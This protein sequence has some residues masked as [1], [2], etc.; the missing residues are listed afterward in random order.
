VSVY[1]QAFQGQD[2]VARYFR[3]L[4]NRID[5]LRDKQE[6]ELLS[7]WLSGNLYDC[8][9]GVGR[10]VGRLPK[11]TSYAGMDISAEFIAFVRERYPDVR[12]SVGDLKEGIREANDS[13]DSVL[14]LRSLSAIGSLA[15]ILPEMVRI[16]RPG[17][18]LVID[19]GRRSL[20][21]F[22]MKGQVLPV[23]AEDLES[24]LGTLNVDVQSRIRVDGLLTRLK[25]RPRVFRFIS[26]RYGALIPDWMLIAGERVAAPLLWQ[27][28]IILLR[29][30]GPE[31]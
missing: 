2:A 18:R 25:M 19:Y 13:Y 17:G 10:F 11:V 30:R 1:A 28:Q 21:G 27:R 23:D 31:V 16:A 6:A 22:R 7:D 15:S 24:A 29:K 12:A 26:G 5:V 8:T 20:R 9:V 4:G 3:K 14:C